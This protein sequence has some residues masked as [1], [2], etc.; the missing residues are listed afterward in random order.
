MP[1]YT[2]RCARPRGSA[3]YLR[4]GFRGRGRDRDGDRDRVRDMDRDRDRVWHRDRDRASTRGT[5]Q[6]Q[7]HPKTLL[8]TLVNQPWF[9]KGL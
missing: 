1:R 3:R 9:Y 6:H 8:K 5:Q 2:P 4:L 7:R